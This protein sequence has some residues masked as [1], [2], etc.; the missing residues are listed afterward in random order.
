MSENQIL[1]SK[2]L[3]TY[4]YLHIAS[5]CKLIAFLFMNKNFALKSSERLI[6]YVMTW[7]NTIEILINLKFQLKSAD[8]F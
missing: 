6:Q 1:L 7:F 3:T 5:F 4:T 8:L 2:Y